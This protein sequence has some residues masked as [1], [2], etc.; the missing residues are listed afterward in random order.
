MRINRRSLVRVIRNT[1][2]QRTRTDRNLIAIYL[3]GSLLGDDYSLGGTVDIDLFFV[4]ADKVEQA[5]EIV[6]LTDEVHLDI[7][8][9]EQSLYRDTRRLRLHSW[10]GPNI[11]A[12]E[13]YFDPGHFMDFTQAS[14][15]GQF[16]WPEHV[17][18]RARA[19]ADSARQI[20]FAYE[21]EQTEAGPVEIIELL[22]A[23]AN[24]ANAVA[25]LRGAP[26][27]E[28]RFLLGYL[29]RAEAIGRPGLHPGFMGL[30]GA[31]NVDVDSIKGWLPAWESAY[32]SLPADMAPA[33]LHPVR[34]Y[35]YL[36]AFEEILESEQPGAVLWPLLR[37]WTMAANT[38]P[39]D[40]AVLDGWRDA[41]GQL[42][43]LG[44]GF[45]KRIQALDAY[46]DQVEETLDDWARA[47]G[48]L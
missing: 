48:V 24:A 18:A 39:Q 11:S 44:D 47:Q 23:L 35:Y 12:C 43:F 33:R 13:I 1:V 14:V 7:S 8:H 21:M 38:L 16:N 22:R 45:G 46:L 36:R 37:T 42:G 41:L 27:T 3:C 2:A 34:K 30:L 19:L 20:W 6:R 26:L 9:H 29:E 31:P 28:R 40:A 32:E 10:M 15:R 5:R 17:L 4:H 25:S